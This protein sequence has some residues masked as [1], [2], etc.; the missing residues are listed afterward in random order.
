[1]TRRNDTSLL[2]LGFGRSPDSLPTPTSLPCQSQ[3]L[4]GGRL[5]ATISRRLSHDI[6]SFLSD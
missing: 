2:E 5:L 3:F 1:M 6:Q 4:D